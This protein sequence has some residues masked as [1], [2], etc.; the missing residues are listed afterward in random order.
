MLIKKLF[1]KK[2]QVSME[3][4]ILVFSGIAVATIACYF[5]ITN[6]KGTQMN[7][8]GE[9]ANKTIQTLNNL[10]NNVLNKINN[11]KIP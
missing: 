8:S 2:G 4:G 7:V 11:I 6:F 9:N 3:I 5:Y 1:S 10:T